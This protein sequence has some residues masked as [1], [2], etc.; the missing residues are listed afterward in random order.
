MDAWHLPGNPRRTAEKATFAVALKLAKVELSN[1]FRACYRT[2]PPAPVG[3][4]GVAN[5]ALVTP[6]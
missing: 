6:V 2:G 5:S 3:S 4:T 1:P